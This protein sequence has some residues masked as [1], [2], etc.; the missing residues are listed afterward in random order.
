[1][2]KKRIKKIVI[3]IICA[4]L[5]IAITCLSVYSCT[6]HIKEDLSLWQNRDYSQ[7]DMDELYSEFLPEYSEY[8]KSTNQAHFYYHDGSMNLGLSNEMVCLELSFDDNTFIMFCFEII[9]IFTNINHAEIVRK[10]YFN[11]DNII[12]VGIKKMEKMVFIQERTL[13]LYRKKYCEVIDAIFVLIC[14]FDFFE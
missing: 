1:M 10:L 7:F 13:L 12:V 11:K 8:K 9:S 14:E 2:K 4:V 3:L 5:L 6:L